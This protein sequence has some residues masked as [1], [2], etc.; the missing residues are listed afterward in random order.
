M[1]VTLA[2]SF[3]SLARLNIPGGGQVRVDGG[4]AFVGHMDA[5]NGTSIIDIRDPRDPKVVAHVA[6]DDPWSHSHKVRVCGD[7]MVVNHEQNKRHF[8]RKGEGLLEFTEQMQARERRDPTDVEL[9]TFL[10]VTPADIPNTSG[11][12]TPRLS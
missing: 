10:D 7:L 3:R 4:Y 12:R 5:P 1:G 11:K 9:A 8:H 6:M 2:R